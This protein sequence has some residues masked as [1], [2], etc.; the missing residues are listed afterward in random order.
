MQRIQSVLSRA[1]E[2]GVL[3]R[4]PL[5]GLKPMK[6]DK[7]GRVRFLSAAEEAALRA[8]L[9]TRHNRMRADRARFNEWRAARH[10]APLPDLGGEMLDHLKPLVLLALNTGMRRGE[11]FSL[12]W[13]DVDLTAGIVT[14]R[15]ASAK[16]GQTRRIPLNSEAA[17]V[18]KAWHTASAK[19]ELVF[20][21]AE[22]ERLTNIAKSWSGVVKLAGIA[23]F[24]FHDLRHSF[25]SKLV[26]GGTDL[27]TVRTL[28]GHS[29]ISTTLIYA[30]LA[31]DNLRAAVER[32]AG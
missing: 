9:D 11:L 17:A 23:G 26:Q 20:P 1:V 2:W 28:L 4:H 15:A 10:L 5:Q 21:G 29:E 16:S 3:D 18:L 27:N 31:P 30:H 13:A 25:A 7:A 19:H 12:K 14:V 22:G 6:F 32:M 24:N 8:A